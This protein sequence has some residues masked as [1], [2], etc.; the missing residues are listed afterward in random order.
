[1]PKY[2]EGV[3]VEGGVYNFIC[4]QRLLILMADQPFMYAIVIGALA[5]LTGILFTSRARRKSGERKS[6]APS[7][8]SEERKGAV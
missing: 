1:M 3:W 8:S 2:V 4:Y 7:P 5:V 6:A